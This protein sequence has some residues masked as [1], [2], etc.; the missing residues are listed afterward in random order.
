MDEESEDNEQLRS[1]MH[2]MP[3][4]LQ[5]LSLSATTPREEWEVYVRDWIKQLLK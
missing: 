5:S 4:K 1:K 2:M 3:V